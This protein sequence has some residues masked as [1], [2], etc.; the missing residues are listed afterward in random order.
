LKFHLLFFF[1]SGPGGPPAP[2]IS[3]SQFDHRK[4]VLSV[5]RSSPQLD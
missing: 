5:N 4:M 2:E 1:L 3:H